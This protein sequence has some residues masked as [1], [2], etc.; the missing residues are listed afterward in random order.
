MQLL[1]LTFFLPS[2]SHKK[3]SLGQNDSSSSAD[4]GQGCQ[5]TQTHQ[6]SEDRAFI[7]LL[8]HAD[9]LAPGLVSFI[10]TSVAWSG[11]EREA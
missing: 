9:C 5:L 7:K 8:P 1:D 10:P 11:N 4:L 3:L 2:E 6:A